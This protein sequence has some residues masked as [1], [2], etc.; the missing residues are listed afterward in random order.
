MKKIIVLTLFISGCAT[1][2]GFREASA[3]FLRE[4]GNGVGGTSQPAPQAKP[5][6]VTCTTTGYGELATTNCLSNGR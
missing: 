4:V 5:I 3:R 1:P 2:S 6:V